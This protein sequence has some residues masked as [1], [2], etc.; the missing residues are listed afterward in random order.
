MPSKSS[1]VMAKR[2]VFFGAAQV[3]KSAIIRRFVSQTFSEQYNP[4]I[5]DMFEMPIDYDGKEV[6]LQILD[7]SGSFKFPAMHQLALNN[8]DIFVVVYSTDDILSYHEALA[9]CD[10]IAGKRGPG[11]PIVVVANKNDL[12]KRQVGKA[13]AE[14]MFCQWNTY[15]VESSAKEEN[16]IAQIFTRCLSLL[17]PA[18]VT[19]PKDSS[20]IFELFASTT[21]RLAAVVKREGHSEAGRK[22]A[23]EIHL[24]TEDV[25]AFQNYLRMPPEL[26]DEIRERVTPAIERQDTQFRSALLL[27]GASSS[28]SSVSGS[29]S[30]SGTGSAASLHLAAVNGEDLQAAPKDI[31]FE[32]KKKKKCLLRAQS[33]AATAITFR[34]TVDKTGWT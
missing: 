15:H 25:N 22:K 5:E 27:A 21:R 1:S 20:Q 31:M 34:A 2:L 19:S 6:Y 30:S 23:E 3:G 29:G 14:L 26:F 24:P 28:A 7:T 12:G 9:T 4:T 8:G 11:M 10:E 32:E 33:S 16:S 18:D 13:E 17:C